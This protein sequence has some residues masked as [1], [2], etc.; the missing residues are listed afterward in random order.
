M[1]E[2]VRMRDKKRGKENDSRREISREKKIF[3]KLSLSQGHYYVA[4]SADRVYCSVVML[5]QGSSAPS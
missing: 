5:K 3:T 4:P 1:E 2:G